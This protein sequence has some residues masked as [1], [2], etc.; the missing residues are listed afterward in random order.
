MRLYVHDVMQLRLDVQSP[1]IP[2]CPPPIVAGMTPADVADRRVLGSSGILY[3]Q[4][5]D[6][7]IAAGE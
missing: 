5:R 1:L 3:S 7:Q 2:T 6:Q 4:T